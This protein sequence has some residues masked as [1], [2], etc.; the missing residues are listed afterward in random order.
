MMLNDS[1]EIEVGCWGI[2][3]SQGIV[4]RGWGNCG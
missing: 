4:V 3:A 1:L 2:F